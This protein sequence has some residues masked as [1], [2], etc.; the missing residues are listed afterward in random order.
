MVS[1]VVDLLIKTS[2]FE[3]I[4]PLIY[5]ANMSDTEEVE[6]H[7][8][9]TKGNAVQSKDIVALPLLG[10]LKGLKNQFHLGTDELKIQ[11]FLVKYSDWIDVS[12]N[13]ARLKKGGKLQVIMKEN[14][15]VEAEACQEIQDTAG[16]ITETPPAISSDNF[17]VKPSTRYF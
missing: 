3:T 5:R 14:A 7:V 16:T 15:L 1:A 9:V 8:T 12:H 11:L 6:F 4:T 10:L 13:D 2:L 17:T